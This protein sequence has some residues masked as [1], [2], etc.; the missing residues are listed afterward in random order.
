MPP[1]AVLT[2]PRT[3]SAGEAVAIAFRERPDTRTFGDPTSGVPTANAPYPLSDGALVV[4]TTA[5][6]PTARAGSTTAR[7]RPTWRWSGRGAATACWQRPPTGS[8]P[9]TAAETPDRRQWVRQP[10]P[11]P[12]GPVSCRCRPSPP[13]GTGAGAP[14]PLRR[15]ARGAP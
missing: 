4:L 8:R 15:P 5:R 6:E 2:G 10:C 13:R 12:D 14:R 3:A 11:P 7:S 9:T 1:V